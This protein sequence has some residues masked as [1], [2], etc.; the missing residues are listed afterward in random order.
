[1]QSN[2]LSNATGTLGINQS[3]VNKRSIITQETDL[4]ISTFQASQMEQRAIFDTS[5]K[6]RD[7]VIAGSEVFANQNLPEPPTTSEK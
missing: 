6:L 1:M 5:P 2:L 3:N 7:G 4:Q